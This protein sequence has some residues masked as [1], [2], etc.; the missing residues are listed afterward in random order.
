LDAHRP[1]E[2]VVAGKR[3]V[4]DGRLVSAASEVTPLFE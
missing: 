2:V 4:R 3:V 1:R